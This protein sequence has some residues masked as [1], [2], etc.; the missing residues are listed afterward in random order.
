MIPNGDPWAADNLVVGKQ[1][2]G[3][4]KTHKHN[5]LNERYVVDRNRCNMAAMVGVFVF[6]NHNKLPTLYTGYINIIKYQMNR[7]LLL[8]FYAESNHN[9]YVSFCITPLV[10]KKRL[11]KFTQ[12]VPFCTVVFNCL[13]IW[14]S[15]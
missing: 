8:S 2:L 14:A 4:A 1:E 7:V 3:R 13:F 12:I 10:W 5:L 9:Y 6:E 15:F 11:C